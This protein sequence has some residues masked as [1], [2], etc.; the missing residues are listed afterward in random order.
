MKNYKVGVASL[1]HDHVWGELEHWK[2]LPNVEVVACGDVNQTLRERFARKFPAARVYNSWREMLTAESGTLDIVQCAAENSNHADIIEACAASGLHV[3]CEKPM[4][5]THAQAKRMADAAARHD[6]RLLINWP[7]AWDPAYREWERRILSGEIGDVRYVRYR[8][9][10]NGPREIG[11]D[12]HFV[13]WLY[14][15]EKNGAGA[16]MDYCC[17]GAA[18]CARLLG[19]ARQV[20]ALRGVFAKDYPLPDDAAV[21]TL[22]YAHALGV[23][24][25]SWIQ[26]SAILGPN[27]VAYGSQGS[28]GVSGGA[29]VSQREGDETRSIPAP[30]TVAPYRSAPE[31]M[32]HCLETGAAIEGIC[33]PETSLIAQESLTAGLIAA[34]T[35]AAQT[36]ES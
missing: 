30:A 20:T 15:A 10:H 24:E 9:A 25:A 31:Y 29:V 19:R 14:D 34:D 33:S 18:M 5:A 11:C 2:A 23:A 12:P 16:Y 22:R 27:P 4:A 35:G 26:P 13:E 6:I 28:I 17:Y 32:I 7:V 36:L 21:L 3:V 1:V 8:S